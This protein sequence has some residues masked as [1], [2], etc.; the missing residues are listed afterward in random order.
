MK[1]ALVPVSLLAS[2]LLAGALPTFAD[3]GRIG[4]HGAILEPSCPATEDKL[5]CPA[6]R[7]GG[8]VIRSLDARLAQGDPRLSLF[9]YAQRRDP[10]RSWR[11]IE[12][13]YR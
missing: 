12:V 8:A 13:T 7:Q 1:K 3:G 10:S 11:L 2:A 9:D 6:G 4:F 5:D